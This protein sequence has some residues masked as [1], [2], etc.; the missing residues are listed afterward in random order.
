LLVEFGGDG[1][2]G[3]KADNLIDERA[4]FEN[5]ESRN[6]LNSV[7][8][9]ALPEYSAATWSTAGAMAR[10]GPHQTAQKSTSTGTADFKTSPS[11][12]VFVT[13]A[14]ALMRQTPFSL[15]EIDISLNRS[16]I[17]RLRCGAGSKNVNVNGYSL[18][19]A[20]RGLLSYKQCLVNE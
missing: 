2:L 9:L 5:R 3:D 19:F 20:I 15:H 18:Y 14:A 4:V 7:F 13:L 1:V 10:Q 8:T 16:A 11:K 12:L 6:A 17:M